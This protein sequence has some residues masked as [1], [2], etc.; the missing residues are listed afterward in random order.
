[1]IPDK[2]IGQ[3]GQGT[4]NFTCSTGTT[5]EA[6]ADSQPALPGEVWLVE[7]CS[8]VFYAPG[9]SGGG[10][11]ADVLFSGIF[12][13]PPGISPIVSP[14]GNWTTWQDIAK[15]VRV[16]PDP[17]L[18]QNGVK[19]LSVCD[20][21]GG[22]ATSLWIMQGCNKSFIVPPGWFIRAVIS[23]PAGV[24]GVGTTLTVNFLY[25]KRQVQQGAC[26]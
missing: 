2:Y 17:S 3:I 7:S 16:S 21:I 22:V 24:W 4:A 9:G 8:M 12:L 20:N 11:S 23:N 1:M 13:C 6:V 26:N 5:P 19:I 14:N 25:A 15:L 10:A 18:S